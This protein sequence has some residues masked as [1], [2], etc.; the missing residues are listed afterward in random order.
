[1]R[2]F[3]GFSKGTSIFSKLIEL[4][5]GGLYSHAF[6][7]FELGGKW[8][9]VDSAKVGIKIHTMTEFAKHRRM[10]KKYE[11]TGAN[12]EQGK[13][14]L[15]LCIDRSFDKYPMLEIFGNAIQIIVKFLSLGKI[16]INNPLE[17]GE[18]SPRCQE[19]VAIILRD[20][21]GHEFDVDL[22]DTDLIWLDNYLEKKT[23]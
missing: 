8:Y 22:D 12:I 7:A 5:Q 15:E 10:V 2:A 9:V 3:V 4:G 16:K 14:I 13:K 20:I 6:L 23:L 18:R 19:F 21:F 1:M 11:I 17:L